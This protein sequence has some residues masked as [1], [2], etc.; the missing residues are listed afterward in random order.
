MHYTA[1]HCTHKDGF[2]CLWRSLLLNGLELNWLAKP[3]GQLLKFVRIIFFFCFSLREGLDQT[4]LPI[5]ITV[6]HRD[7]CWVTSAQSGRYQQKQ[8]IS[9]IIATR[10]EERNSY[11]N[12]PTFIRSSYRVRHLPLVSPLSPALTHSFLFSISADGGETNN[13]PPME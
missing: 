8:H 13:P 7:C 1:F 9:W 6:V 12:L 3:Q 5:L 2:R 4:V 10:N 11:P